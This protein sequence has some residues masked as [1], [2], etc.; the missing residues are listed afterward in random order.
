MELDKARD[1]INRIDR[2]IVRLLDERV[3]VCREIGRLKAGMK[4]PVFVPER[5]KDVLQGVSSISAQESKE[6]I[7][8]VY[9]EIISMCRNV[10]RPLA[11]AFLGPEGSFSH[12]AAISAFGTSPKYVPCRRVRDIFGRVGSGTVD[13][14]IV[15]L[16]NSL[17]G[18]I[19]ETLDCLLDHAVSI[20]GEVQLRINQNLIVSPQVESLGQ[21]ERIYSHPQALAQ[22]DDYISKYLSR[23]EVVV[24]ESTARAVERI[25]MDKSGGAIGSRVAAELNGLKVFASNIEDRQNNYTRFALISREDYKKEGEKTS[26]LFSTDNVPGALNAILS[27]FANHSINITMIHSRP[28]ELTPWEYFFFLDFEG[29]MSD[30]KCSQALKAIKARTRQLKI[31]GSYSRLA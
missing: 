10:Q 24:T 31:L 27:E 28:T 26:L 7:K 22:C 19:N 1:K 2:D 30:P 3:E 14:G 13:L 4:T 12:E 18:S 20:V 16:E 11:M 15:P 6:G 23:A 9:R 17:E 25:L 21:I 8:A 5:E 29:N